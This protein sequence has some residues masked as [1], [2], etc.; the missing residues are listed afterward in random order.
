[1][2]VLA[3][4]K[5]NSVEISA[6]G[7]T[8]DGKTKFQEKVSFSP[9][10]GDANKPWSEFTPNGQFWMLITN[11]ACHG[12]FTPGEDYMLTIEPAPKD[13]APAAR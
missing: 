9:V 6:G 3:K 13:E 5:C 11:V 1:M 2:K 12:Q 8:A 7:V 10:Y 4:F